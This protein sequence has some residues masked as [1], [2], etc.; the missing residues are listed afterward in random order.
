ML[1][2]RSLRSLWRDFS[3]ARYSGTH[4]DISFEPQKKHHRVGIA[5]VLQSERV[6]KFVDGRH[7][8]IAGLEQGCGIEPA[9][10]ARNEGA[11]GNGLLRLVQAEYSSAVP[12]PST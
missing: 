11:P 2:P 9:I 12:S 8:Q 10:R 6:T 3:T 4:K 7:E 5:A 1:L